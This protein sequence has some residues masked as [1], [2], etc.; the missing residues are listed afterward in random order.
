[1]T[2]GS[3]SF[4]SPSN[5][6]YCG[7]GAM[8]QNRQTWRQWPVK[9]GQRKWDQRNGAQRDGTGNGDIGQRN[10]LAP[11]DVKARTG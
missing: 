8:S 9:W 10:C 3:D 11:P 4:V 7:S 2:A 5:C 6:V 1:M